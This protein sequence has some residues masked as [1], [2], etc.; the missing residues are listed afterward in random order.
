MTNVTLSPAIETDTPPAAPA[1]TVLRSSP[2]YETLT[3][4]DSA[5]GP[6]ASGGAL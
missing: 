2:L 1:A 5:P 6:G 3:S 4:D